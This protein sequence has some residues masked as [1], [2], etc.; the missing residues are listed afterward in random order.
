MENLKQK[1]L[2]KMKEEYYKLRLQKLE[3]LN[4]E[5]DKLALFKKN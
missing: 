5:M 3:Q 1:E 4:A 2:Q